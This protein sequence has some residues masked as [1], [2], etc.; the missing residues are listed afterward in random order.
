[1]AGLLRNLID[2]S[3]IVLAVQSTKRTAA[4]N[5]V[6]RRLDGH[7][8]VA[9]FAGFYQELLARDRLDTTCLGN[10][11]ALPHARTEHVTDLVLAIGRSPAGVSF[12]KDKQIVRLLFVL[13]TPKSNPMAYLQVV[14]TLCKIFKDSANREA[15]LRADTPEAFAE[16]LLAAEEK[17]LAPA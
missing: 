1:M 17:L 11:I 8:S 7:P 15:L 3:R 5:E 16:V 13:G 2:P 12:E 14:S 4:L 6:A 10:E 9:N